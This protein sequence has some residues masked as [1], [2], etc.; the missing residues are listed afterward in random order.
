MK[1][2]ILSVSTGGGHI[3]AA[4]ALKECVGRRDPDSECLI[5]DVFKYINP[6]VDKLIV[7]S[8]LK[9]IANT[10]RI[11]G[12]LYKIAESGENLN[13]L[14]RIVNKLL[15]LRILSIIEEF[16]PAII[17][18]THP[19]SLQMISS[20]KK[21]RRI[22]TPSIVILTDYAV[23]SFW[24]HGYIDA[25]VVAHDNMK[26]QMAAR[27]IP[28]DRIYTYGI[29]VAKRFTE[30]KDRALL[31]KEFGLDDKLTLLI[32]GGSLGYGEIAKTF[33]SLLSSKRDLQII[34][35]SGKNLKLKRQLEFLCQKSSKKV[36]ILSYTDNVSEYMDVSDFILT[37]TGGVTISEALV[38]QLPIL[39]ISPLPGAE[40]ENAHFLMNNGAAA[41]ILPD[42]NLNGILSQV[43]DNPLRVRQMKEMEH[44]LAK[45]NASEDIVTLMFRLAGHPV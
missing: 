14:S 17:V 18:C 31:L 15:S 23:H 9:T 2:L 6:I 28:Q 24:L 19:F 1:I 10:P 7:G 38:K 43:V 26:Y 4:E 33:M 39:I 22:T 21:S 36:L 3:K 34:V 20:L 11:Y 41:R 37:K 5:L 13:D 42:D 27:G 12:K 8:Y 40:E 32:M 35:L 44:F 29:P 45:P 25:Y 30:K 16:K